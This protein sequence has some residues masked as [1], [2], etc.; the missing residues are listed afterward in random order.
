[1]ALYISYVIGILKL[2][3]LH[4][5]VLQIEYFLILP[6]KDKLIPYATQY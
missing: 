3:E 4:F 6:F 1:M 2:V 5:K